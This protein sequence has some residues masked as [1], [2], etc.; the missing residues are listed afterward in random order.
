MAQITPEQLRRIRDE[1]GNDP[2]E[3]DISELWDELGSVPAVALA[4]LRPLYAD[5]LRAAA[6]GSATIPGAISVGAPAQPSLLAAQI[7][8]LEGQLATETGDP[9]ASGLGASSVLAS[10]AD[11]VR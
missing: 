9:D 6:Q 5:A 8:R 4:I 2:T 11:R 10:R 3:D 7:R 1:V